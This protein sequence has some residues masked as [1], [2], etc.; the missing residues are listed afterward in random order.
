MQWHLK[1]NLIAAGLVFQNTADSE[2]QLTKAMTETGIYV[3]SA[4]LF[5]K[6]QFPF[7]KSLHIVHE[8]NEYGIYLSGPYYVY[9][10]MTS[11]KLVYREINADAPS[12]V[13]QLLA[14]CAF[15]SQVD[16]EDAILN[17]TAKQW[18]QLKAH[19]ESE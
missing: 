13:L 15:P 10:V 6:M 5:T 2:Q 16:T 3:P 11:F 1:R 12:R 18:I 19:Y 14:T 9:R 17:I 7:S 8:N 4:W